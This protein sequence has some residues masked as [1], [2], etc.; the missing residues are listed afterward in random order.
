MRAGSRGRRAA[1]VA[2]GLGAVGALLLPTAASAHVT[3]SS[4]D[5]TPGAYA[6]L[7][8]RV[9]GERAAPTTRVE[10]VVPTSARL[11]EVSVRPQLGW[12]YRVTTTEAPP[13]LAGRHGR[14]SRVVS[15]VIWQAVQR[16]I[17]NGEFEEFQLSAGPLPRASALVLP[18]F[19]TY[20]DGTVVTWDQTG[21]GR[22]HP[23]PVLRITLP[24]PPPSPPA[25]VP[26]PT[27]TVAAE[28][29]VTTATDDDEVRRA[30]L[31]AAVGAGGGALALLVAVA[32]LLRSGRRR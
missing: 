26:T 15:R 12:S 25:P 32:A 1:R 20:K 21:G 13:G 8:F 16:G 27:A 7:T 9:Q 24:T 23:A 22:Q 17:K 19:Q 5:S 29:P 14:V 6:T 30:Q 18:V 2:V 4:T 3:V 10:V 28:P 11:A 31:L